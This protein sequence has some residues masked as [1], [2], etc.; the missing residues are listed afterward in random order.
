MAHFHDGHMEVVSLG[1]GDDAFATYGLAVDSDNAVWAATNRGLYHW[2]DGHLN[3]M[4]SRN[5]LPCSVIYSAISDNYGSFCLYARCGL[6][7]IPAP[8]MASWL[9]FPDVKVSVKAFDRFDGV[10][11]GPG[12]MS[13]P[14][15]SKS[16][17]GRLWFATDTRVQMIDPAR[18][19]T[20]VIPPPV[21]VEDLVSDHKCFDLHGQLRLPV[22]QRE[23]EINYTAPSFTT[24]Q[25]VRFRHK[26]EGHDAEWQDAG[27]RRQAFYN[28]LGPG[29][30]R[31]QVI[32]C[33]K[34][35]IWNN[36]GATLA[37]S[38]APA[39]YQTM[40]F[41]LF[42]MGALGLL[43]WALYQLRR[44][45]LQHELN[46]SLEARVNERMRI[47]RELH[48]TLL[49][50]FHGLIFLFQA[51]N[52]LPAR[53]SDAKQTLERAL[54]AAA[55]G[56]EL[57]V[58]HRTAA[59][60]QDSP[61]FLVE[62]EGTPQDLHPILHD[63]IYGIAVEALRNAFSYAR[64]RRI[65]VELR[66]GD[67]ELRVRI[68]DDGSG[69]DPSV[70]SHDGRAGHWGLTGMRERAKRIGGQMDLWTELGAGTEVEVRIAAS[71]AY[72]IVRTNPAIASASNTNLSHP[73]MAFSFGR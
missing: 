54:G 23:L 30:Y 2:K 25:Q 27:T 55:M 51:D 71:I 11:A 44:R 63:E 72:R 62:V 35:G 40:W 26:P 59:A 1:T 14:R 7:R 19:Y 53:P 17:D 37:F 69:I 38:I 52:L 57:A 18:S 58:H 70:L 41:R 28:D 43:L 67:G 73:G 68:R 16:P 64:A 48:D 61:T 47:A 15:G 60:S 12:S 5:G 50:S 34:D 65:E 24:P 33:N 8:D 6:L 13:Q 20:D 29:K 32:A 21:Y 9:K 46:T 10:Q 31:F 42:C 4:D 39:W 66:Y 3:V 36:K 49:Q 45:Q 56:E 22:L